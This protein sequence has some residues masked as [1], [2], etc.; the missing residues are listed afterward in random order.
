M[1]APSRESAN[2]M[3][4]AVAEA[5]HP[6]GAAAGSALPDLTKE[7]CAAV[8]LIAENDQKQLKHWKRELEVATERVEYWTRQ[9][10]A[11]SS[12]SIRVKMSK[13]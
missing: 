4:D 3:A 10:D 11:S 5:A 12:L 9:A 13:W 2:M 7:Q 8:E 1:K 6:L